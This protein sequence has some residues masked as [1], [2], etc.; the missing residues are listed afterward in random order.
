M[1]IYDNWDGF[2][3]M[4]KESAGTAGTS[5][6]SPARWRENIPSYLNAA[7]IFVEVCFLIF[8]GL[9]NFYL[10]LDIITVLSS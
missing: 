9:W 5:L 4:A 3:K 10:W 6:P 1:G 7:K 8:L 2:V